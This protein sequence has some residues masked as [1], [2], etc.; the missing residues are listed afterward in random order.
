MS[1]SFLEKGRRSYGSDDEILREHRQRRADDERERVEVKRLQMADQRSP[2][3]DP[4][5]RIRIWET[6]HGLR[7]P[8]SPTHPVLSVIAAA[9]ELTLADILA[10][11]RLRSS[12]KTGVTT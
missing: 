4:N 11:Q 1:T 7:L 10:V 5:A 3:N 12:P 2:L 8:M 6:V 9:T